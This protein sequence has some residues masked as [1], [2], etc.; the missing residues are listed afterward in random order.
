[1]EKAIKTY[2]ELVLLPSFKERY[3]YLK[4]QGE[5]ALPTFAGHR[6]LNQIF[7]ASADWKNFRRRILVRDNGCDLAH[8]DYPIRGRVYIHHLEPITLEDL[9]LK[10]IDKL[11]CEENAVCVSFNT[12]QAIHYGDE[13]LIISGAPIV[14][15]PGDTCPWR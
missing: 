9:Q 1:M 2:S 10:R 11:L 8:D 12:H 14:R 4:L 15:T 5:V 6:W 7:Y 13:K 3:E